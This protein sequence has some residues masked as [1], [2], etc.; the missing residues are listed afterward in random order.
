M[1]KAETG[2]RK[3]ETKAEI[4]NQGARKRKMRRARNCR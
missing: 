4:G 1:L 3:A 2:G